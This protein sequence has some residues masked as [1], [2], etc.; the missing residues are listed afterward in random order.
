[1]NTMKKKI[2]F[3]KCEITELEN[4]GIDGYTQK[5]TRT[6]FPKIINTPKKTNS[7]SINIS[8]SD[9]MRSNLKKNFLLRGKEG[10]NSDLDQRI[11]RLGRV[12]II[13]KPIE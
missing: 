12:K 6:I 2:D 10:F 11:N 4:S 1:M 8:G 5:E 3:S 7:I 13:G 9:F